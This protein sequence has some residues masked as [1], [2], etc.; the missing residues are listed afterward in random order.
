MPGL[1]GLAAA[2]VAVYAASASGQHVSLSDRKC[3]GSKEEP[4][5]ERGSADTN[6]RSCNLT[7]IA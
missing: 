6:C 7:R 4:C 2:G 3:Q 1:D 5:R